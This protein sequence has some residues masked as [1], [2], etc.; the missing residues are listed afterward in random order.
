[1]IYLFR[2]EQ[3]E[4]CCRS[5]LITPGGEFQ[6]LERPWL[7]NAPNLSCIPP[8]RYKVEYLPRSASGKYKSCYHVLDVPG[9]TGILI[10][11]GNIVDH[12]RGCLLVGKQRGWLG[13]R[14]AVFNSKSALRQLVSVLGKNDFELTIIG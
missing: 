13:N 8:G 6:V 5:V 11:N 9:R 10:H 2:D 14:R 3:T 12:S 4:E 7:N 1:M